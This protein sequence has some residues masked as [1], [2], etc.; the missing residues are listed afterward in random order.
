MLGVNYGGSRHAE[1]AE[2]VFR[3]RDPEDGRCWKFSGASGHIAIKLSESVN[4]RYLAIHQPIQHQLSDHASAEAPRHLEVWGIPEL[5]D[6]SM[7]VDDALER[8]T[9]K[10]AQFQASGYGLPRFLHETDEVVQ[11]GE[12]EFSARSGKV[13]QTFPLISQGALKAVII[14][15]RDNWGGDETCVHGATVL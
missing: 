4:P 2:L 15:I 9:L 8:R 13:S 3:S 5:Q 11:I 12:F 6:R 7:P 1:A 10:L 14:D